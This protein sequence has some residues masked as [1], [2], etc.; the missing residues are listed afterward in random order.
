MGL[1]R[2]D[3]LIAQ[4]QR[5]CA[6]AD[7]CYARNQTLCSYLLQMREYYRWA[8]EL[9]LGASLPH[10]EVAAWLREQEATWEA[11]ETL[12][13][14]PITWEERIYDPFDEEG[15]NALADATVTLPR[16]VHASH[17]A[18]TDLYFALQEGMVRV[19]ASP[20]Y[21]AYQESRAH[22]DPAPLLAAAE[23]L[24]DQ[25]RALLQTIDDAFRRDPDGFPDWLTEFRDKELVTLRR[26]QG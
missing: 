9:P 11:L 20:L 24:G 26:H 4:I 19:M 8:H 15:I 18:I 22:R 23:H 6:I 2:L 14:Q 17:P 5:N 12:D 13:P 16:L 7:A 3:R 25:L 21:A 1:A 10:H